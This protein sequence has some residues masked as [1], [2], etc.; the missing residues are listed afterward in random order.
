VVFVR[1]DVAVPDVASGL[2]EVA[3][4]RNDL[5][6]CRIS[7]EIAGHRSDH[8]LGRSFE[9]FRADGHGGEDSK[10]GYLRR[11][12]VCVMVLR[13]RLSIGDIDLEN[14]AIDDFEAHQIGC[15]SVALP[16]LRKR[17]EDI[18]ELTGAALE[19]IYAASSQHYTLAADALN[20]F[21]GYT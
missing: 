16:S 19:D 13:G 10:V 15:L 21:R 4:D 20:L 5:A 6:R 1:D 12:A 3:L 2:V 18:P 7:F 8:A 14:L 9:V 11:F 17:L